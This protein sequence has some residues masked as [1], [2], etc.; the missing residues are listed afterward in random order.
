MGTWM[1]GSPPR[2]SHSSSGGLG[3]HTEHYTPLHLPGTSGMKH[4]D[5]QATCFH[6]TSLQTLLICSP[7]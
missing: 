3:G 1:E 5:M 7:G 2:S 6:I 4:P